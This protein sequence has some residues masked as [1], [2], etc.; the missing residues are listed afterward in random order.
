MRRRIGIARALLGDP[1]IV[2]VDEPTTGLDVESRNALRET[3]LAV[4]GERIILFSTHIASDV[5]AAASRILI[6]D[7]GQLAFDG[8]ALDL[9][10]AARGRVF[11]ARIEDHDLPDFSHR[12]R[13]TTRVRSLAGLKVR[14]I[15]YGDAEPAGE[16]VEPNL[17]EAYL[18]MIGA[19]GERD[20]R[21]GRSGSLLDLAAWDSRK[22]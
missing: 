11:E 15:A 16:V 8:P 14:A 20:Q 21:R 13:V 6:L 2:I 10:A 18:A 19:P 1:R 9:V 17:E 5:A 4:A 22:R 7:R 12:F 3:L